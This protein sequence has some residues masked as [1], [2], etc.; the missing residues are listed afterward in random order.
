[1]GNGHTTDCMCMYRK[2]LP[3]NKEFTWLG[4]KVQI[5]QDHAHKRREPFHVKIKV[6]RP[7]CDNFVV[8]CLRRWRKMHVPTKREGVPALLHKCTCIFVS[9]LW[10][11]YTSFK[12]YCDGFS[13]NETYTYMY[14]KLCVP[15]RLYTLV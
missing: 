7:T 3:T 10:H 15:S 2:W 13:L 5:C 12:L 4:V 11:F 14:N 6:S 9:T 8:G 1:M